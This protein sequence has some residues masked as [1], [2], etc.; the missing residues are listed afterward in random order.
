MTKRAVVYARV[1]TDEQAEKGYSFPTQLEAMRKYATEQGFT[2]S[3]EIQDDYS[4]AK[5]DRLGLARLRK[6]L[7]RGEAEAVI[8]YSIDRLSRNP[9]HAWELAETWHRAGIELHFCNR[10][11]LT[12]RWKAP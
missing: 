1:S 11:D 5:L 12:I 7:E 2:V 8:C 4:G 3:A 10:G 6:M 9:G